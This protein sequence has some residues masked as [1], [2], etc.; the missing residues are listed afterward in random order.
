MSRPISAE[1]MRENGCDHDVTIEVGE[2][3][4]KWGED[5]VIQVIITHTR[6]WHNREMEWAALTLDAAEQLR[7]ELDDAISK[8][9]KAIKE[10]AK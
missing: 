5:H 8:V 10:K 6:G 2:F 4:T 9:K 3:G 7:D 1:E